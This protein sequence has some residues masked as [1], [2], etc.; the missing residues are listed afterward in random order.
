MVA[1]ITDEGVSFQNLGNA[2]TPPGG[3]SSTSGYV[4]AIDYDGDTVRRATVAYEWTINADGSSTATAHLVLPS[5]ASFMYKFQHYKDPELLTLFQYIDLRR[6]VLAYFVNTWTL[7]PERGYSKVTLD[8]TL[9]KGDEILF[10][11]PIQPASVLSG[12]PGY[13]V[14]AYA[15][16]RQEQIAVSIAH[17]LFGN[18]SYLTD[19][20]LNSVVGQPNPIDPMSAD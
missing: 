9:R 10:T 18:F 5:G 8:F 13:R 1:T 12:I 16:T 7:D 6:E 17:P 20:D 3:T 19:G 2:P 14:G 4:I 15:M 11:H